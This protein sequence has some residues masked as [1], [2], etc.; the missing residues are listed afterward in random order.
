MRQRGLWGT[1]SSFETCIVSA[2]FVPD[3]EDGPILT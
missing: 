3:E 2:P 1:I